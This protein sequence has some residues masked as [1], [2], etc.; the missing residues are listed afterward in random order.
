[1]APQLLYLILALPIIILL[2]Y[3]HCKHKQTSSSHLPPGPR[4]LPLIGNLFDIDSSAP[5]RLL[6]RLSRVYGTL[7][8]LKLGRTRVLVVSSARMAEEVMKTQDLVFCS[9]PSLTGS[10]HLSYDRLD[11]AF[12]PYDAYWREIRKICVVHLFNLNTVQSFCPIRE[13]EVSQMIERISRSISY[14]SKHFNLSEAMLSM[15]STIICRTAFGKS[16]E[17]NHGADLRH[18][19]ELMLRESEAMFTAFFFSDHFP[20]LGFLDRFT[21][22]RKELD[23]FYQDIIDEHLDPKRAESAHNDVLDVLLGIMNEEPYKVQLTVDH[24]KGILMNIFIAG[25]DTSAATVVWAMTYLIKNPIALRKAQEEVREAI[26]KKGFVKEE[27]IERLPY[28]S[29]VVKETMRLQPPAPLLLPRESSQDC[30]LGGY[31]ILAKTTVY[32]NA[33]AIGRDPEAWGESTEEFKPERFMQKSID[34]KGTEFGLIPFGA[35]RRMCPGIHIGLVTVEL[36][37]ANLL[38]GFD[39]EMPV[40]TKREDLD[41]EV[42]PGLTMHKKNALWLVPKKCVCI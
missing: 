18:K 10:N 1:M 22:N 39:W 38:Y 7:M 14:D 9:R 34:M 26:E 19:L 6:W 3:L 29:A 25:T 28:L 8:S 35:G 5:H 42:S 20:F 31:K 17:G 27:D 21:K 36:S 15:T 37:L 13:D 30:E 41:M 33:W 11:V 23:I 32:V 4:S 40:G 24:I 16:L 2:I 12:S